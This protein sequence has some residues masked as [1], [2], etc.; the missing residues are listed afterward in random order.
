MIEGRDLAVQALDKAQ[1]RESEVLAELVAVASADKVFGSPVVAG[2]RTV[3]PAAEIQTGLGFGHGLVADDLSRKGESAETGAKVR[4]VSWG[5][6]RR[7]GG[8]Q[9]GGGGGG[10]ASGRPVAV[11]TIDPTGVYVQPVIDR[12]KIALTALTALGA[13]GLTLIRLR[14][15]GT[16]RS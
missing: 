2:D 8:P 15:A 3:I 7:T 12:T 13:I 5:R 4:V 14:R 1:E 11:V 16:L 9:G 10:H 6:N